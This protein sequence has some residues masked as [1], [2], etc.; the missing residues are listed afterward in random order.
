[1]TTHLNWQLDDDENWF[2]PIFL[3]YSLNIFYNGEDWYNAELFDDHGNEVDG[4]CGGETIE[5]VKNSCLDWLTEQL[6]KVTN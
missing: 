5:E 4:I 6:N 3:G 1:M 2:V